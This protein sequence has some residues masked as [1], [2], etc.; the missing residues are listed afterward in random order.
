MEDLYDILPTKNGKAT[1]RIQWDR[2]AGE[3]RVNLPDGKWIIAPCSHAKYAEGIGNRLISE[4]WTLLEVNDEI[5][6]V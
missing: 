1:K 6:I 5:R 2:I 4:P 3:V